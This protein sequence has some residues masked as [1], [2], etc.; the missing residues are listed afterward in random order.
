MTAQLVASGQITIVDVNDAR[1]ITASLTSTQP[2]QQTYTKDDNTE[3]YSPNRTTT[4]L[5]IKA[6]VSISGVNGNYASS[7]TNKKWFYDA[8][9]ADSG[10]PVTV[11]G[12]PVGSGGVAIV[13]T[14]QC[15]IS[16]NMSINTPNRSI[17]FE[18]DYVDPVTNL[19]THVVATTT[20]SIVTTGSNAIHVRVDPSAPTIKKADNTTKNFVRVTATLCRV[21]GED[22]SDVSYKW[23]AFP[24]GANYLIDADYPNVSTLFGFMDFAGYTADTGSTHGSIGTFTTHNG[25]NFVSSELNTTNL[26]LDGFNAGKTIFISEKAINGSNGFRVEIK[27]TNANKT[28]SNSFIV[29]D[30]SDQ[31]QVEIASSTGNFLQNGN[32]SSVLTAVVRSGERLI[33]TSDWTLSW[34][35]YNKDGKR[36]GFVDT[37]KAG[38]GGFPIASCTGSSITWTGTQVKFGTNDLVKVIKQNNTEYYYEAMPNANDSA[39]VTL[40]TSQALISPLDFPLPTGPGFFNSND[41]IYFA[42]FTLS[43]N[44]ITIT[45]DFVESKANIQVSATRP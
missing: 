22:N 13:D 16:N 43:T 45:G 35:L 9:E 40:K 28:Y 26:P 14:H 32:G 31:Y 30:L 4:N 2:L 20:L 27:D 38:G 17:Y 5:V 23:Y 39:T 25:T 3:T 44:P 36:G 12:I 8:T 10:T 7:L 15:T 1:A 11:G 19:T 18:G 42:K 33:D 6:N 24:Y 34:Q 41:K 29:N 37:S 21:S